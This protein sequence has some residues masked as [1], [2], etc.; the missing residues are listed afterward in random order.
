MD[1]GRHPTR[2]HAV[3]EHEAWMFVAERIGSRGWKGRGICSEVHKLVWYTA[4]LEISDCVYY[5]MLYRLSVHCTAASAMSR[6]LMK[7][8]KQGL[9]YIFAPN[10]YRSERVMSCVWLAL[11]AQSGVDP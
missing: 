1:R 2:D 8:R 5:R 10:R 11:D 3:T 9:P 7:R 4:P 6:T